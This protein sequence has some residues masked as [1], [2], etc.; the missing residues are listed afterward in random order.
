MRKL[1]NKQQN[2]PRNTGMLML[3]YTHETLNINDRVIL[4]HHRVYYCVNV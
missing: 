2:L 1:S 3:G 4:Q